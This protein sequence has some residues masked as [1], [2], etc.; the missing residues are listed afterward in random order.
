M[1]KN[2]QEV[3]QLGEDFLV[4]LTSARFGYFWL[5]SC[6]STPVRTFAPSAIWA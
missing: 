6:Q 3:S 5:A 4:N 2:D 1:R